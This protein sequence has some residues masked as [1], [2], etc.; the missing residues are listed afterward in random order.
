MEDFGKRHLENYWRTPDLI[1]L[2][3]SIT[4]SSFGMSWS[5]LPNLFLSLPSFNCPGAFRNVLIIDAAIVENWYTGAPD[6]HIQCTCHTYSIGQPAVINILRNQRA[7]GKFHYSF[8]RSSFLQKKESVDHLFGSFDLL[9]T[10]WQSQL[11]SSLIS[12]YISNHLL[13]C[14]TPVW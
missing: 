1:T 8:V 11:C 3:V 4:V 13:I 6:A 9:G 14:R 7:P 2:L 5:I 12:T 10:I